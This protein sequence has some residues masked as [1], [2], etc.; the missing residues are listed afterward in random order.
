MRA[1]GKN[2]TIVAPNAKF[3]RQ[4]IAE[5][6]ISLQCTQQQQQHHVTMSKHINYNKLTALCTSTI[7]FG[8]IK[9]VSSHITSEQIT[10]GGACKH[11]NLIVY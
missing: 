4:T 8:S 7:Q 10:H 6:F 11:K 3:R 1:R 9:F 5:N 2:R